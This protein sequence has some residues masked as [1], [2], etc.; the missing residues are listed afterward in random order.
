[1]FGKLHCYK[2]VQEVKEIL[3]IF[4][5][6]NCPI[7]QTYS[8]NQIVNVYTCVEYVNVLASISN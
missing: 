4:Q 8:T 7:M 2:I 3:T 1:M 6:I 5:N